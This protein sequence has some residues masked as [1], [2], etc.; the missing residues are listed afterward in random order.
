MSGYSRDELADILLAVAA[1]LQDTAPPYALIGGAAVM[2]YGER[3]RTRD[4]D[5]L[6]DFQGDQQAL[7]IARAEAAGMRVERK[8]PW[9]LR[10]WRGEQYADLVT[11]EVDVQ[12]SAVRCA[13]E[14]D[15]RV[16]RVRLVDVEHLVALKVLAGRPRD[17]QDVEN[18]VEMNPGLDRVQ[19]RRLLEPWGL[20][21]LEG[22][23]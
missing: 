16:G 6:V 3:A 23:W 22:G 19:V 14:A 9:H 2:A 4:V 20:D 11:A 8:A 17:R 7:V 21:L 15:L 1:L 5:F 12:R 13:Q 10:L 18:I